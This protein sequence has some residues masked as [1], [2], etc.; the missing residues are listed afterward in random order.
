MGNE[1]QKEIANLTKCEIVQKIKYL[2]IELMNKNID[3]YQNNYLKVWNK[4]QEDMIKW[5]K[6][7]LLGRIA[8]IKMNI[9]PRIL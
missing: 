8:V 1:E 6:L 7:K 3:L 2:G 9:L 4:F 5:N